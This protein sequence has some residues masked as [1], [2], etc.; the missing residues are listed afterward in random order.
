MRQR[1]VLQSDQGDFDVA[2]GDD[3]GVVAHEDRAA[4]RAAVGRNHRIIAALGKEN[5]RRSA[6][7]SHGRDQRIIGLEHNCSLARH[8][9]DN[10]PLHG[11]QLVERLDV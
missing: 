8:G 10:R 5:Y 3:H 4:A 6:L 1:H 9:V 2:F 7:A 11:G